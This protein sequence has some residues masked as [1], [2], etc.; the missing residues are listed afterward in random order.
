MDVHTYS[1]S[2]GCLDRYVGR[3]LHVYEAEK[4]EEN[5]AISQALYIPSSAAVFTDHMYPAFRVYLRPKAQDHRF[6]RSQ[7]FARSYSRDDCKQLQSTLDPKR[8][9]WGRLFRPS[10]EISIW[11]AEKLYYATD[12]LMCTF[13]VQYIPESPSRLYFSVSL[14]E[15]TGDCDYVPRPVKNKRYWPQDRLCA[16]KPTF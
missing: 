2:K 11:E 7:T 1:G 13:I 5:S 8:K 10:H 3:R 16:M 6:P 14:L 9:L 4:D 15:P 12:W